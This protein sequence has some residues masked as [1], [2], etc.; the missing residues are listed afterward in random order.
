[1]KGGH[2]CDV[3]D[4]QHLGKLVKISFEKWGSLSIDCHDCGHSRHSK[5]MRMPHRE[6]LDVVPAT[7][8]K[9]RDSNQYAGMIGNIND[10]CTYRA[11]ASAAV[12][13]SG[14]GRRIIWCKAAP[15]GT[16]GNTESSC[17]TKKLMSAVPRCSRASRIAGLTCSRVRADRPSSPNASASFAKSGLSNGVAE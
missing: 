12:S 3:I 14:L 8:E 17:S 15:L 6:C 5:Q 4:V 10:E 13:T 1:M 7:S 11:H 16:I 9:R 2:H